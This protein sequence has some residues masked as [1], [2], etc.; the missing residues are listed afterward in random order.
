MKQMKVI[1]YHFHIIIISVLSLNGCAKSV[2]GTDTGQD[3]VALNASYLTA[4]GGD[5]RGYYSPN[6]PFVFTKDPVDSLIVNYGEGSLRILGSNS[7]TGNYS[8]LLTARIKPNYFTGS[9]AYFTESDTV[10]GNWKVRGREISFTDS[11]FTRACTFSADSRGF[12]LIYEHL[13][14]FPPMTNHVLRLFGNPNPD[15]T[16]WVFKKIT[17]SFGPAG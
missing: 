11:N 9:Y 10:N 7:D 15:S 3:D 4:S 16:V 12:Y 8:L 5:P 17:S 2:N 6:S 1:Y 14:T 13:S